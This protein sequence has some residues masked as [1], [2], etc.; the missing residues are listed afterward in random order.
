MG[1][2][3]SDLIVIVGTPVLEEEAVIGQKAEPMSVQTVVAEGII[4]TLV[5]SFCVGLPG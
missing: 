3:R 1:G 5:K 4:T 2:V